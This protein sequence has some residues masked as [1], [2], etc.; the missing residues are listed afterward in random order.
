MKL[1]EIKDSEGDYLKTIKLSDEANNT[2]KNAFIEMHN[3]I[4]TINE[5]GRGRGDGTFRDSD[6]L[7]GA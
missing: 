2:V 4:D 5:N 7:I 1:L 3:I 6:F